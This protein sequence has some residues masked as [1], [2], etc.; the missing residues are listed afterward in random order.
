MIDLD[1]IKAAGLNTEAHSAALLAMHEWRTRI[2][3]HGELCAKFLR[4]NPHV[5]SAEFERFGQ[6]AAVEAGL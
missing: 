2:E 1:A 5:T 6:R 3:L 4:D